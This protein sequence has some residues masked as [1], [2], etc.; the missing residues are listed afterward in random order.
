MSAPYATTGDVD[1]L[2][3]ST[4]HSEKHYKVYSM[5][6]N[7]TMLPWWEFSEKYDWTK[8]RRNA[9]RVLALRAHAEDKLA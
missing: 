4:V 9:V 1:K 2:I 3:A 6:L 8:D 7:K 5:T